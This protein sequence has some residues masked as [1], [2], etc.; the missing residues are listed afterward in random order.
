MPAVLLAG[1]GL[2]FIYSSSSV[3]AEHRL[4][5]SYYFLKRQ[6]VFCLLG[7][8]LLITAKNLPARVWEKCA[9]PLL[10]LSLALLALL[11]IPGLGKTAG[12]ASRW[13]RFYGFSFQPSELAKLSLAVY[14]AYSMA[15]KG[16][17]MGSF[18]KGLLPHLLVAGVFMGLIILQPDLGT[19]VII[20]CWLMMLLFVG[21][22]RI[23]QITALLL[24]FAPVVGFLIWLEPYRLRRWWAFLEPWKD[25][26]G[27]G[28]QI[29]HSFL[30]F[31]SG[32]LFGVG[33]GNSKQ[34][35]LYLPE[36]HTDFILSIIA[37][38]LGLMGVATIVLLFGVLVMR[39]IKAA[40]NARDLYSTYLALG[41][42]GFIGLQVII[43]MG[44]V[45]GLLPT[46]GLTLPLISYGG[47]SLVMNLLGIGIL[48][49]IAGR[50]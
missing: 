32:G 23:Y 41:I 16:P 48:L 7:F 8:F 5:D 20:G 17:L 6:A 18:T 43:N 49:S 25:P 38:E 4:G 26:H 13:L 44:V 33:L 47:S 27:L 3:V 22:V 30:A 1:F 19:A 29:I 34:K 45:M 12:G 40:L 42:T 39:G 35:L 14:I 37:E 36:P 2:V 11:L 9:Y 21:G 24:A 15:K 28:F 46:K 50:N 31:G 10:I